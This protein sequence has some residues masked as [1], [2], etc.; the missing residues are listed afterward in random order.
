MRKPFL[1]MATTLVAGI[2]VPSVAPA[3]QVTLY[4]DNMRLVENQ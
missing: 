2:L 1:S 4:I 3:E